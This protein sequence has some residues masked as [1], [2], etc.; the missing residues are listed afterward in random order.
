M[1]TTTTTSA[2]LERLLDD[3]L[4]LS[5]SFRRMYSNHLAMVLVALEQLGAPAEVLQRTFDAHV[6]GETE[7]R[8]DRPIL[9]E[10]IAEVR[11]LGIEAT[12][13]ARVPGVLHGPGTA[14]FHPLI[15]LGYALDVA[16]AGQVA[17]A[18]LDWERRLE[19]R[20]V[21][22]RA[23]GGRPLLDAAAALAASDPADRAPT[24]DLDGLAARPHVRAVLE[25]LGPDSVHGP[26]ELAR[27]ALHAHAGANSFVT[28]HLVT[29]ARGLRTVCEVLDADTGASLVEHGAAAMLL[30]YAAA[31]APPLPDAVALERLRSAP[32]PGTERIAQLAMASQDPHVIKLANVALVEE[33]RTGEVLYRRLAARAVGLSDVP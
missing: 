10:R 29:G 32:L 26:E 31:G 15:R 18:L 2:T 5:P 21:T 7:L 22:G 14:L 11:D 4:D 33:E 27:F 30:G 12:V 9:D 1:S 20:P 19:P 25:D 28:L 17:A 23:R 8:D 24:Y 16:H 13:R 6:R 3:E